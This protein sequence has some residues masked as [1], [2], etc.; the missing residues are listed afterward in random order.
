MHGF[1]KGGLSQLRDLASVPAAANVTRM[2]VGGGILMW[3]I[4]F[5]VAA[6]ALWTRSTA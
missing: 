2:R 4:G 5:N 1:F 6:V 3:V